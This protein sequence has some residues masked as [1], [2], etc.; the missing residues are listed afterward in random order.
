M[1]KRGQLFLG[2]YP[3]T[4]PRQYNTLRCVIL[5]CAEKRTGNLQHVA[6]KKVSCRKKS[7]ISIRDTKIF[8]HSQSVVDPV[9][10][11]F[12]HLHCVSKDAPT[13]TSCSFDKHRLILT[14][15]GRWHRHIFRNDVLIQLVSSLR[16]CLV[17]LLLNSSDTNDLKR[18]MFSSV[19]FGVCKEPVMLS[20]VSER[21]FCI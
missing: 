11:F 18:N 12:C 19:D 9:N 8:G 10:K 13:S 5:T 16:F 15:F 20:D 7:R 4:T 1:A 21:T 6:N 17:Y 2:R 3:V 14:I